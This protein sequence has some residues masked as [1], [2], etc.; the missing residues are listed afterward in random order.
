MT[1]D[2]FLDDR[3]PVIENHLQS[4]LDQLVPADFPELREMMAYHMGWVGE[5]A[6]PKARGKRIRPFMVLLSTEAFGADWKSALPAAAS[7][8]YLHNF[9]LIHDDI[10]DNSSTRRNRPTLWSKWGIPQSINSGDLMFSMSYACM[11]ALRETTSSAEVAL[12]GLNVLQ[13]TIEQLVRGQYLDMSFESREDITLEAY[14]QMI[15]GKTAALLSCC[16]ELGALIANA[17]SDRRQSAAQFGRSLGLAFQVVDDWLGVWGDPKVTGKSV[18]SD[19]TSRKKTIPILFGLEHNA[20]FAA[21]WQQPINEQDVPE[22]AQLLID[23]GA[24]AFTEHEAD[25]LTRE[26]LDSLDLAFSTSNPAVEA[27]R[28]LA[29]KLIGR[30]S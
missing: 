19:L 3:L 26:A 22:L 4:F 15:N 25:R 5:G 7:V 28:E 29:V 30:Q 14:W 18:G 9:S 1:L 11:M 27:L 24:Q 13:S 8:S 23:S 21:R 20:K 17:P 12:D 10:E 2:Q 16:M 6:G